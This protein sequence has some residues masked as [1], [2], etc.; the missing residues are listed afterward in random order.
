MTETTMIHST[1]KH[2]TFQHIL[3]NIQERTIRDGFEPWIFHGPSSIRNFSRASSGRFWYLRGGWAMYSLPSYW[4]WSWRCRISWS[5]FISSLSHCPTRWCCWI[6]GKGT[7]LW[8]SFKK[9][10]V[11]KVAGVGNWHVT[12]HS[13]KSCWY[14]IADGRRNSWSTEG[15]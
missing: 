1:G 5:I 9:T 15:F 10:S 13:L 4:H 3:M 12:T 6:H 14:M 8:S 2:P 11:A 7:H